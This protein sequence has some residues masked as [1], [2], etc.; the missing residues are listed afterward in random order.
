MSSP[1]LISLFIAPLN[2][3][4]VP[5][6]VTGAVAAIIYGEPRLTNDIDS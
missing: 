2:R 5:Y 6:M 3:L 4:G 1:D